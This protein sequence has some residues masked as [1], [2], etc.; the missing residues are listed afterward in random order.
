MLHSFQNL[1]SKYVLIYIINRCA[2]VTVSLLHTYNTI[3][4]YS[5]VNGKFVYSVRIKKFIR[6]N[7]DR[8]KTSEFSANKQF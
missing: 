6:Y 8:N 3:A 2:N 7:R 4:L 5:P 1:A